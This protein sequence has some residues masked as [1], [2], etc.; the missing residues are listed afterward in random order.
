[1]R[2]WRTLPAGSAQGLGGVLV[3]RPWGTSNRT[4]GVQQVGA[5]PGRPQVHG[6]PSAKGPNYHGLGKVAGSIQ[7]TGAKPIQS[8]SM[9]QTVTEHMLLARPDA[10]ISSKQQAPPQTPG[11]AAEGTHRGPCR[12]W[13][14]S[15]RGSFEGSGKSSWLFLWTLSHNKG[16]KCQE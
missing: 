9:I 1:M 7:E 4:L 13:A 15:R 2:F 3:C 12:R 14:A 11:E 6:S 16:L 5:G 10:P 8:S